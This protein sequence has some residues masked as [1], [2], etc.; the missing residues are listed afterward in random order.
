[1]HIGVNFYS[2]KELDSFGFKKLGRN[3]KIKKNVGLYFTENITI[4]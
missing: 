2:D 4:G 1:M 3:V